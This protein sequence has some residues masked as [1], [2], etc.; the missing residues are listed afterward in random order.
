MESKLITSHFLPVL[1]F[2]FIFKKDL[3]WYGKPNSLK[4]REFCNQDFDILIDL[5]KD[6]RD[7]MIFAAAESGARFK[8]GRLTESKKAIFDMMLEL[9]KEPSLNELTG[10]VEKYV[11]MIKPGTP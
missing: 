2:D 11:N 3:N 9:D 7:I 8:I 10:E 5:S 4:Y 1:S 6:F